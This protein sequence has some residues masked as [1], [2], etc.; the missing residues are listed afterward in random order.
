M[1]KNK[2]SHDEE[3]KPDVKVFSLAYLQ[4]AKLSFALTMP[5]I[6]IMILPAILLDIS[7]TIYQYI[8]FTAYK[9]PKVKR[10][11]YIVIDRHHLKYLNFLEKFFCLYCGYFNGVIAYVR[12]V[13]A[14]TEEFWCP[15]KHAQRGKFEHHRY[16]KYLEYGDSED[17]YEKRKEIRNKLKK[18]KV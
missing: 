10:S 17:Y 9:I 18:E 8:N 6:L 1:N 13:G 16:H 14:K 7:A 11:E 4:R 15:I 12:E 5:V 3:M 2:H